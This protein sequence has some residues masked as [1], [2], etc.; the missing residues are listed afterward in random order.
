MTGRKA[1]T[2]LELLVTLGLMVLIMGILVPS[3]RSAN[4]AAMKAR[5]LSN[6][7]NLQLAQLA[8]ATDNAGYLIEVGLPHGGAGG[9]EEVAWIN[10][11]QEYY[12]NELIVRSPLDRS[13]HWPKEQGGKGIPVPGTDDRFRRTSYGCNNY[14]D[15]K[16]SDHVSE[17]GSSAATDRLTKIMDHA[18][19]VQFL[20]MTFQG[21]YAGSDHTHVSEWWIGDFAPHLPPV[22]AAEQVQTNAYRGPEKHW[23]SMS[24]Y[25]FLDGHVE[26]LKFLEVYINTDVNRFDPLVSKNHSARRAMA[27]V[28]SGGE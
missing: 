15:R 22:Q 16:Y 5:C 28:P 25:G 20:I 27:E 6:L 18:A 1:F 19:T 13:P 26:T 2:I 23:E 24:N 10:T 12:D 3:L 8:Y 17:F 21:S 7:R 9:S 14:L 11:L 4:R